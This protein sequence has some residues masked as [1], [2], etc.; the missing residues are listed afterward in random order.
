MTNLPT[1]QS[2][3]LT[4]HGMSR[5]LG[6]RIVQAARLAAALHLKMASDNGLC[7]DVTIGSNGPVIRREAGPDRPLAA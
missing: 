4:S 5:S 3:P 6:E 7:P 1:D 2:L